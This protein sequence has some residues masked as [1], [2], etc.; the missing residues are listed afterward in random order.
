[1][2]RVLVMP[3]PTVIQENDMTT[4]HTPTPA[5]SDL[6]TRS[7][8]TAAPTARPFRRH[9][10]ALTGGALLWSTSFLLFGPNPT[11]SSALVFFGLM[12]GA[13]QL[14]LLALLRVLWR[15]QALGEGRVARAVLRVEAVFVSLAICSTTVDA[16][17]VS[18]L[19]QPGWIVLDAFW[20]LSMLGMFFIGIR[21][22]VAG[23]WKGLTRFWPLVAESWAIVVIPSMGIFGEDVA[24]YVA[25]LHLLVGYAVLG[26]LV[27]RKDG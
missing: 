10:L 16:I 12:S 5:R 1:M 13:F 8:R 21:I 24:K 22:A 4:T 15:T 11:D 6:H 23:R 2:A 26:L 27:S 19:S 20:P 14:G 9:G 18:D 25:A 17:G 3:N 7:P